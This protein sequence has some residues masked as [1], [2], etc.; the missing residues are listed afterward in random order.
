[1]NLLY[2]TAPDGTVVS[3]DGDVMAGNCPAEDDEGFLCTCP[4]DHGGKWHIA[5]T[6][7]EIVSVWPV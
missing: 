5:D 4:E 2:G 3:V 7:A 1:M 6:G